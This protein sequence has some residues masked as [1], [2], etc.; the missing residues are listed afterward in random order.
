MGEA[1]ARVEARKL[2]KVFRTREGPLE[3]LRGIDL[4]ARAGEF[5]S[6]I[7]PSGSGKSTLF[8]IIT[9]LTTQTSGEA[10][11]DGLPVRGRHGLVAYMP[12]NDL[13][14]PWRRVLDNT[15]LGLEVRGVARK[16][17]RRRA[18]KLFRDFGLVGFE[19]AWPFELSGGMRQRAALLRTVVQGKD[20]LLLDEPLGALDS[21]TRTDMQEWLAQVWE[22]YRWTVL[23]ITHDIREAIFLSDRVYVFSPRPGTVRLTLDIPLPRPRPLRVMTSTEFVDLETKLLE[24]LREAS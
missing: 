24:A 11:V 2:S 13:L 23:L 18:L 19:R 16:E 4:S 3:V 21:L 22:R 17:A 14:F 5:V 8:N 10:L 6:I 7:G 1:E 12:Q 15:T 9:G 20:I